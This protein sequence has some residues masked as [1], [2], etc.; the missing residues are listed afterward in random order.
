[1]LDAENADFRL[2]Q[3]NY[4]KELPSDKQRYTTLIWNMQELQEF[5]VSCDFS[6]DGYILFSQVQIIEKRS[7]VLALL[8]VSLCL[9]IT[10]DVCAIRYKTYIKQLNTENN[11]RILLGLLVI[12]DLFLIRF[13]LILLCMDMI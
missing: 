6:G 4:H 9:F 2:W 11:R 3:G 12:I 10:I 8:F 1:M 5:Y 7:W 13:F